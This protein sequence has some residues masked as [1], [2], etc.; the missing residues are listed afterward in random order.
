MSDTRQEHATTAPTIPWWVGVIIGIGIATGVF[1]TV[2]VGRGDFSF[3]NKDCL[4]QDKGNGAYAFHCS[5]KKAFAASLSKFVGEHPELRV[6]TMNNYAVFTE[7]ANPRNKQA[8]AVRWASSRPRPVQPNNDVPG[9][10]FIP[11]PYPAG[12]NPHA[13]IPM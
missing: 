2:I 5:N 9:A 10:F 8:L 7:S 1:G 12:T 3:S 6:V 4:A 13:I 11:M